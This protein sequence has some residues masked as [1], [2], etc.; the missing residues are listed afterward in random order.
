MSEQAREAAA[1][2]VASRRAGVVE[3][4]GRLG[5]APG[6]P[7]FYD[8]TDAVP[9]PAPRFT[10]C[11]NIPPQKRVMSSDDLYSRDIGGCF[12]VI[13]CERSPSADKSLNYLGILVRRHGILRLGPRI[14]PVLG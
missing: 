12:Y 7:W 9:P 13:D 5:V 3:E 2:I 11:C 1:A 10:L 14:S 8:T 4:E 6:I